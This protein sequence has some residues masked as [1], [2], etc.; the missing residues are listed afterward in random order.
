MTTGLGCNVRQQR[1]GKRLYPSQTRG[2]L[3]A[4]EDRPIAPNALLAKKP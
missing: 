2:Q 3:A 4:T 1:L